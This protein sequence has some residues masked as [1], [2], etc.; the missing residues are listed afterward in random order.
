MI[1]KQ[2]KSPTT[3][4]TISPSAEAK[5]AGEFMHQ[6]WVNFAKDPQKGP[7]WPKASRE[8]RHM[9]LL[10][11]PAS[12]RSPKLVDAN[13]YNEICRKVS[14][15][16]SVSVLSPAM[17]SG[18]LIHVD[19]AVRYSYPFMRGRASAAQLHN[20]WQKAYPKQLNPVGVQREAVAGADL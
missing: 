19:L 18:M 11:D 7:G 16:G 10:G 6:T 14:R 13:D 4:A 9:A 12:P 3:G 1:F 20:Q 17:R 2:Y 15:S 5:E 8:K